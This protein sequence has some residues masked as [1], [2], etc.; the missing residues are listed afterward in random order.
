MVKTYLIN[1]D[2]AKDRLAHMREEL[3]RVGLDFERI[4]AV[5][6]SALSAEERARSFSPVR[7]FVASKARRLKDGEIGCALSHLAVYRK[8]IA[9]GEDVALVLEDD[10][11]LTDRFK[12]VLARA[13]SKIDVSKPEIVLFSSIWEKCDAMRESEIHLVKS[14]CCTDA[15]LVTQPAARLILKANFPVITVAD[16][17]RRWRRRLGLRLFQVFPPVIEQDAVSFGSA[18][19]ESPRVSNGLLRGFS[20]VLDWI[21]FLFTR[22]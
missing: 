9:R 1:L 12:A 15:Y 18:I 8:M 20:D 6:G 11:R 4:P 14:M 19:G 3:A 16:A 21:L 10:V 5:R 22:R 7:S 13:L 2:E 17:Y